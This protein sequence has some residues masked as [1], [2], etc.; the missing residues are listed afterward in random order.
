MTSS[1]HE[2]QVSTTF[3][4]VYSK[5]FFK[6]SFNGVFEENIHQFA[7]VGKALSLRQK[8]SPLLNIQSRWNREIFFVHE[9][10]PI[11]LK[12]TPF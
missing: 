7:I 8:F 4:F 9:A 12:I 1:W 2:Y 3:F 5:T 6:R 10:L 11:S